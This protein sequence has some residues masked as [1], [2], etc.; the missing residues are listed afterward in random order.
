LNCGRPNK[1]VLARP[2]TTPREK[3]GSSFGRGCLLLLVGV[4]AI[5]VVGAIVGENKT[6]GTPTADA[7]AAPRERT[8]A[9]IRY[10]AEEHLKSSLRDPS[11]AEF[12]DV[13]VVHQP[14]DKV[15]VC[16]EVNGK[17]GFGGF[18]GYSSFV[19]VGT[20]PMIQTDAN[21]RDFVKLWN[22]VC[23]KQTT[24]P[25]PRTRKKA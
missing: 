5:G 9:E 7:P 17:N 2:T 3:K 8:D 13:S 23:V 25:K 4:A 15:F 24:K 1:P 21:S 12:R 10:Y 14:G 11:S 20:I 19:V 16:G 22:Q 6:T 18:T